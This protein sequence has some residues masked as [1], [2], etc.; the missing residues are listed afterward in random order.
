LAIRLAESWNSGSELSSA[1]VVS[2]AAD[3]QSTTQ[4]ITNLRYGKR[5]ALNVAPFKVLTFRLLRWL[6]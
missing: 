3:C 6:L 4:Q 5:R 1:A 2:R